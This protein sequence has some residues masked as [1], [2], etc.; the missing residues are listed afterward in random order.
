MKNEERQKKLADF[1]YEYLKAV[2]I[3]EIAKQKEDQDGQI[4]GNQQKS[5]FLE[6]IISAI[7]FGEMTPDEVKKA[8]YSAI[9]EKTDEQLN[10]LSKLLEGRYS[11]PQ[12]LADW[13]KNHP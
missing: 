1:M 13:F 8:W 2:D 4:R 5:K 11:L 12:L 3:F 9:R 7:D 10:A 6:I